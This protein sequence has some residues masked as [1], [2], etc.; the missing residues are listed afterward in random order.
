MCHITDTSR[1]PRPGEVHGKDY[2]FETRAQMQVDIDLG[3]YLEHG[4]FKGN[5]YG[6][7]TDGVRELLEAGLQTIVSPH[8]QV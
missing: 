4:E 2:F 8:Y 1:P 3:K 5:L 7:S 6:T